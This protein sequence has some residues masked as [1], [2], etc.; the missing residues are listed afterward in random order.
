MSLQSATLDIMEV[1]LRS[2]E[3]ARDNAVKNGVPPALVRQL[4]GVVR[5][6][7]VAIDI[8]SAGGTP[9]ECGNCG[10]VTD[11]CPERVEHGVRLCDGCQ[12]RT[13]GKW[14]D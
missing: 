13:G 8:V 3:D 10:G 4:E 14:W 5:N 6:R 1:A 7:R 12:M 2:A 11:M 9:A